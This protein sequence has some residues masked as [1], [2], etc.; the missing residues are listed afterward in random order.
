MIRTSQTTIQEGIDMKRTYPILT[1]GIAGCI[2]MGGTPV[3]WADPIQAVPQ[4]ASGTPELRTLPGSTTATA[5]SSPVVTTK[6]VNKESDVF[7]AKLNIPVLSGMKD[8]RYQ[9]ELNDII[10]RN[11]MENLTNLAKQAQED[12]ASAKQSGFEF[13]PY[14]LDVSYEVKSSGAADNANRISLKV[15]TYSYTGGANGMPFVATYNFVDGAEAKPVTLASLF[16][17]NYKQ[18]I[19]AQVQKTIQANPD[20]YF[21]DAFKGISDTQAFYVEKGD[22]V[23]VFQKYDIAPGA[24]G[25]PEIRIPLNTDSTVVTPPAAEGMK[26]NGQ[27]LLPAVAPVHVNESGVTMIPLRPVSEALGYTLTWNAEKRQ[28]ELS[29][30]AQWT[31][32]QDGKDYYTI[33]KMA[34]IQLGTAPT[35]HNEMMY[36]PLA[37]FSDI[38]KQEVTKT[39]GAISINAPK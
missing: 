29:K 10:E 11:A 4:E 38:L 6:E 31:A 5:V 22:A 32:V 20:N 30:G 21:K 15:Q 27:D 39:N 8:T 13:R 3:S 17:D 19:D 28:A 25:N 14:Q 16:G 34:P 9:G 36:V 7:T 2:L 37:F 26:I 24:A 12:A 18:I 1:L 23:L 33:N 35:I